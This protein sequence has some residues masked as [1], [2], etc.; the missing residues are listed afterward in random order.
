MDLTVLADGSEVVPYP[1]PAL[2][3]YIQDGSLAAHT[4]MA[5]LCHWH[6]DVEFL[7]ADHG[8]LTYEVGGVS[9]PLREGDGIFVNA[10]QLHYGHTTDGSN[11]E[12]FCFTFKPELLCGGTLAASFVRPITENTGFTHLPLWN[13]CAAHRPLLAQLR[14]A[15]AEYRS[16]QPGCELLAI[17]ALARLWGQMFRLVQPELAQTG[18]AGEEQR[19]QKRMLGFIHLHYAE[20]LSLDRIAASAGVGRSKCCRIFKACLRCSPNAYL[21]SYRL[22]RAACLLKESDLPVTEVAYR[23][24]FGGSSYFAETFRRWKGCTPTRYRQY[25]RQPP[26]LR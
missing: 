23:C 24:G 21:T 1:A 20:P 12:Y 26:L 25:G 16:G 10:R 17:A 5:A 3:L 15:R 8:G 11:C 18:P 7:L 14:Q 9:V 4:G 2:P 22:E 19:L 13:D 6:E